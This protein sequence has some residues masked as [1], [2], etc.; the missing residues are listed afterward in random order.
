MFAGFSRRDPEAT[1][2]RHR[3]GPSIWR[4]AHTVECNMNGAN[5]RVAVPH[6]PMDGP[7]LPRSKPFQQ[8]RLRKDECAPAK[9]YDSSVI[10]GSL[11]RPSSAD[12]QRAC[13]AREEAEIPSRI[14]TRDRVQLRGLTGG[15]GRAKPSD[16]LPISTVA[17]QSRGN[18]GGTEMFSVPAIFVSHPYLSA[19]SCPFSIAFNSTISDS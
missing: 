7:L 15:L 18:V 12:N 4:A 6:D 3:D 2:R 19:A 14:V 9:N 11:R 17:K 10:R 1:R 13:L 5:R 8:D 16:R